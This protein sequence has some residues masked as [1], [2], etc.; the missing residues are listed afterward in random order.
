MKT[1]LISRRFTPKSLQQILELK[2][3]S[4]VF[5]DWN[6]FCLCCYQTN[7]F[8]LWNPIL[9]FLTLVTPGGFS[10]CMGLLFLMSTTVEGCLILNTSS[11]RQVSWSKCQSVRVAAHFNLN[12]PGVYCL[13]HWETMEVAYFEQVLEVLKWDDL[14]KLLNRQQV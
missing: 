12:I 10:L 5:W 14:H 9:S 7:C 4:I 8:S 3:G 1:L 2:T 11:V 13:Q 6:Y